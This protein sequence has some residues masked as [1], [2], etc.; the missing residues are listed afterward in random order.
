MMKLSSVWKTQGLRVAA[1]AVLL[2]LPMGLMAQSKSKSAPAPKAPSK[3]A[4]SGASHAGASAG[5]A[6]HGGASANGTHSTGPT[7]NG[8]HSSGP[9]A[10]GSHTGGGANANTTHGGANANAAHG[11]AA[12]P[13]GTPQ[14]TKGGLASRPVPKGGTQTQLK[15][16]SAIQKRPNGRV[17]DVHDAKRGM[18]VHH[19]LNGSKQ[20]SVRRPDGSRVVGERGRPGYVERGFH[21]GGHDYARRSY[22][23]HGRAYDRYYRGYYYG[24]VYMNVYAPGFYYGPGF[25][26]WAYNP[27]YT[28]ISYGWG[29]GGSPWFGFYG[30]FFTPYPVYAS[31]SFWLTDYLI[32]TSLAAEYAAQQEAGIAAQ[33]AADQAVLDA[34]TKQMIADEVKAELALENAEAQ[35]NAQNQ[36]IDPASSGLTRLFSDGHPHVFVAGSSLDVVDTAG[37]ECALSDSD[38]LEL[39]AAPP[40]NATTANLVVLASKGGKECAKSDTVTVNVADLQE[41]Q[42]HMRE[43]VDQ[44]LQELQAKQGKG[45]IP[46]APP[47]AQTAPVPTAFTKDAPPPEQ[48]GAADVNQQL[49]QSDQAE[50]EV[51]AQAAAETGSP[52]GATAPA[53]PSTA[54]PVTVALGQTVDQVTSA[55]GQPTSVIDLGTKKIYKYPDMKVT[56]KAGKVADVQ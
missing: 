6:S 8:T 30:G 54:A 16:G 32:S 40:A 4:S 51:T 19:G 26:G 49:A 21:H 47:S 11:G 45:G 25:Y 7:A 23:Y 24:G 15:G 35:Q 5:G 31:A 43:T 42:N 53:A 17:S 34:Q 20:V 55:L 10:N 29:W 56:F 38:A 28:P 33:A 9:T 12:A 36:E 3:P 14:A 22:Y 52:I 48:N 13:H 18:D 37:N 46:A 1:G 41:M 2:L 44:G 39:M 27:W 50:Q